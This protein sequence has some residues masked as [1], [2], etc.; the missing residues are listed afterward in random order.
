MLIMRRSRIWLP[1]SIMAT[2]TTAHSRRST[3]VMRYWCGMEKNMRSTLGSQL[4][5]QVYTCTCVHV[6]VH[7]YT[8]NMIAPYNV[9][10]HV[11][12]QSYIYLHVYTCTCK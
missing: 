9:H 1:S 4:N 6:P 5:T 8:I 7:V 3:L 10:V 2:S 12:A 11:Y